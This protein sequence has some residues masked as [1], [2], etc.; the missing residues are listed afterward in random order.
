MGEVA[1]GRERGASG[2]FE[3]LKEVATEYAFAL[4]AVGQ[5]EEV[6]LSRK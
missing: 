1:A 3:G 5:V 6:D 2:R 4:A